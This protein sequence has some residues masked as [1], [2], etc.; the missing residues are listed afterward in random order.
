MMWLELCFR[1]INLPGLWHI[2]WYL[3]DLATNCMPSRVEW[4]A[5]K[6]EVFKCGS[7]SLGF[8]SFFMSS[9]LT[10][11]SLVIGTMHINLQY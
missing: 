3:H 9:N 8:W 5:V 2:E 4:E 10:L 1:N 7:K 11:R 6:Q